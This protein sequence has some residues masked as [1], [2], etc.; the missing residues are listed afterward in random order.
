MAHRNA[1][2]RMRVEKSGVGLVVPTRG[3]AAIQSLLSAWPHQPNVSDVASDLLSVLE[4][5]CKQLA[6]CMQVIA[7]PFVFE[8]LLHGLQPVP[9]V[10]AMVAEAGDASV[11]GTSA[12][13]AGARPHESDEVTEQ[14]QLRVDAF[15]GSSVRPA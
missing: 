2:V 6:Y 9:R 3:L 7:S 1:S 5:L 11:N 14:V 8:R 15:V 4:P 13:E 12:P 10:F